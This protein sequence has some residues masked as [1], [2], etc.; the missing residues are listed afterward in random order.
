MGEVISELIIYLCFTI[1]LLFLSYQSRDTDSYDL[2]RDTKN[3]FVTEDFHE[4][5]SIDT[6]WNYCD[7]T[8][9]KRLYAQVWYNNKYI[10]CREKLTTASRVSMRVGA[11]TITC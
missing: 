10:T 8:V 11:L 7:N 5:N 9:L 3:L 4:I 1:V 2:Y 6:W